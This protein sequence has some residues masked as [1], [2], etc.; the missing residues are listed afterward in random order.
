MIKISQIYSNKSRKILKS[1]QTSLANKKLSIKGNAAY[2]RNICHLSTTS[3]INQR[4]AGVERR[5]IKYLTGY[6]EF[7]AM[8]KIRMKEPVFVGFSGAQ[9]YQKA[10]F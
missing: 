8:G 9:G 6:S 7:I 1:L 4:L 10:F 3:S 2:P 5:C